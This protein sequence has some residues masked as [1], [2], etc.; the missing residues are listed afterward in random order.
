MDDKQIKIHFNL[1][2]F[3]FLI[4]S[5]DYLTVMFCLWVA[6]WLRIYFVWIPVSSDFLISNMYFFIAWP[7]L[8]VILFFLMGIYDFEGDHNH[9]IA[10]IIRSITVAAA[11]SLLLIYLGQG[12]IA[13][14][15]LFII[16]FLL[17]S[18]TTVPLM[19]MLCEQYL[20]KSKVFNENILLI[21]MSDKVELAEKYYCKHITTPVTIIGYVDAVDEKNLKSYSYPCLGAL[22]DVENIIKKYKVQRVV[23]CYPKLSNK[24]LVSTINKIEVLVHQVLFFSDILELAT[25]NVSTICIPNDMGVVFSIKNNLSFGWQRIFKRI[26]DLIFTSGILILSF[27]IFAI[28]CI[29]IYLDSPGPII[30]GHTRVGKGGK[31]FTCYKFRT[32]VSNAD[33]VLRE[34]LITNVAAR[35]EWEKNYKLQNDPRVTKVGKILRKLSLDELP[36]LWN[37]IKGDMSLVGPRPI[38]SEEVKMYGPYIDE[39]FLVRPGITGIWQVSGR[40]DTSYDERV[41]MDCW[42]I[43]NWSVWLDIT[44]LLRT[45]DV[46]IRKKGAY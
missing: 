15:R 20:A 1:S 39:F 26:I 8:F 10:T 27:P 23:V 4:A 30:F 21:G 45:I 41:Q 34:H 17:L 42:Y 19:H 44:C 7:F 28:L 14:S 31:E 2:A 33:V 35:L 5:V 16:I 22:S 37:V 13:L 6:Y 38:T 25:R 40:S 9:K 3:K 29:V 18:I 12:N 43:H 46:V 32:M 11:L 24:E 36:Q